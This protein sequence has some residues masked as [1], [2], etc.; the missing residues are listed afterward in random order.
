MK[1][2][3]KISLINVLSVMILLASLLLL[4]FNAS[5]A[6]FTSQGNLIISTINI[7]SRKLTVHQNSVSNPALSE[8]NN[9]NFSGK[10]MPGVSNGLTLILKNDD[11]GTDKFYL[12]YKFETFIAGTNEE[13][14]NTISGNDSA[15]KNINNDGWYYYTGATNAAAEFSDKG[16]FN[17][18]TGFTIALDQILENT[19]SDTITIKVTIEGASS[20]GAFAS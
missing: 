7:N 11:A 2:T 9:I 4:Y 3:K 5:G 10:I 13:I 1:Q 19:N 15:F 16:N 8:T 17:L 6:W 20:V 12:R 14:E 18:L